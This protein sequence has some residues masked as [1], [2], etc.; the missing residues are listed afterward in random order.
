[1]YEECW[2]GN[3]HLPVFWLLAAKHYH[4]YYNGNSSS[5]HNKKYN[6]NSRALIT[7]T[8]SGIYLHLCGWNYDVRSGGD[9]GGA[10]GGYVYSRECCVGKLSKKHHCLRVCGA[11][12]AK[13]A[14]L[15]R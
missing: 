9:L 12:T 1:M 8:S 7:V 5:H 10:E 11:N 15:H 6:Y 3:W 13:E 4:C 14:L 2:C